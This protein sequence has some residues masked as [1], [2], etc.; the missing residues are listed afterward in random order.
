MSAC[1]IEV[2]FIVNMG[3]ELIKGTHRPIDDPQ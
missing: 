2:L 1:I 3:R